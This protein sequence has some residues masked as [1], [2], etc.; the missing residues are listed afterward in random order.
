MHL[1]NGPRMNH[2]RFAGA[3]LIRQICRMQRSLDDEM[4]DRV[5]LKGPWVRPSLSVFR[6]HSAQLG[7]RGQ[8]LAWS[9]RISREGGTGIHRRFIL[10]SKQKRSLIRRSHWTDAL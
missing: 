9:E 8:H 6:S 1:M 5:A 3:E 4:I 10:Q 7:L 2:S